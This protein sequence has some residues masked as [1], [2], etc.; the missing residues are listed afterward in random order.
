MAELR[1]QESEATETL[2]YEGIHSK[3]VFIQH[4]GVTE[5]FTYLVDRSTNRSVQGTHLSVGA[6][7]NLLI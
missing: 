2:K 7:V 3:A 6:L 4:E 1:E 5:R